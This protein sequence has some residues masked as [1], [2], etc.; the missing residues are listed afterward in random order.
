MT[1]IVVEY[2]DG[3]GGLTIPELFRQ[4][5]RKVVVN[6]NFVP[7]VRTE[8]CLQGNTIGEYSYENRGTRVSVSIFPNREE[9]LIAN[10][11]GSMWIVKEPTRYRLVLPLSKHSAG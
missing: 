2:A 7:P 11:S 4:L 1:K 10:E 6:D 9:L 5:R 8:G 3:L